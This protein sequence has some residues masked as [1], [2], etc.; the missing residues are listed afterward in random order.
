MKIAWFTPFHRRSAIGQYSAV[1][2]AELRRTHEPVVFASDLTNLDEAWPTDV[3]VVCLK[4]VHTAQVLQQLLHFPLIVYNMGDHGPNHK[5]VFDFLQRRPGAVV[6]HDLVLRNFFAGYFLNEEPPDSL[7]FLQ[8]MEYCHG[9]PGKDWLQAVLAG[10]IDNLWSDKRVL[11]YHMAEA[12]G[13]WA[14]GIIV[15]SNFALQ[16][17]ADFTSAPAAKINFPTPSLARLTAGWEP[18]SAGKNRIKLLTFGMVNPNKMIDCVVQ[19]IGNSSFLRSQVTYD[20]LGEATDAKYLAHL[21]TLI[22]QF[23]L[24]QV[25]RLA[26]PQVDE[27]FHE[28]LRTADIVVNLR[29]PHLGES[30]WSLLES[31]FASKPTIVWDHGY[32]AE[33]PQGVVQRV[34]S[35]QQ[36]AQV[37]EDLC[38]D[39]QLRRRCAEQ[40]REYAVRTFDTADYCRQFLAFAESVMG[41]R[42]VLNLADGLADLVREVALGAP[43]RVL[44]GRVAGEIG[45]LLEEA[46]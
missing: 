46:A 29:N 28:A 11:E 13:F 3:P 36:F 25:V 43:A 34:S 44:L 2:C 12:A 22:E 30:S 38:R 41:D 45:S 14:Q 15:H 35:R 6:L 21:R 20:I 17:I 24:S 37:L 7:G 19:T 8:L 9:R 23:N 32:Y 33:F 5:L 40:A 10:Q 4:S 39:P 27:E 26:G 18:R 31:L 16:R 42:A 1:V